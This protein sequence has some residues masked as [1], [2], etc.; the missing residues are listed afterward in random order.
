MIY[1]C[2]NKF[3]IALFVAIYDLAFLIELHAAALNDITE[4]F[5]ILVDVHWVALAGGKDR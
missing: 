4:F 1:T 5:G 3:D 2:E